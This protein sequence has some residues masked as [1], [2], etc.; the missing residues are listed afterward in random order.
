MECSAVVRDALRRRGH[1]AWSCDVKPCEGDPRWHIQADVFTHKVVH[2][3]WDGMIAHP[4]CTFL[5]RAGARHM[6]IPWRREAQMAAVHTVRAL[7]EFPIPHIAIENPP[8]RLSTLWRLPNQT[9]Q[10]HMFGHAE[11]K[12]T[13][14]WLKGLP[15]L[16]PT[17]SLQVPERGSR[18]H[19]LWNRVHREGPSR[20]DSPYTD[21]FDQIGER[22][23]RRSRTLEGIAEAIAEQWGDP[24]TLRLVG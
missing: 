1:D 7:W 2:A 12:A 17:K 21:T 10:P 11:F 18:E 8:G 20:G 24:T 13:C 15:P 5:T 16:A 6:S 3:G 19:T 22:A 9:I 4:T 14:L 23:T